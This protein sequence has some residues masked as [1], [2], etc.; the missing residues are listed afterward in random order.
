MTSYTEIPN[1][2][3]RQPGEAGYI[4]MHNR[5]RTEIYA[6][7]LSA[8]RDIAAARFK[9]PAKKRHEITCMIAEHADGSPYVHTAVD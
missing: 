7:S 8:A 1:T 2:A 9:V 4:A 5:R 6:S 3:T